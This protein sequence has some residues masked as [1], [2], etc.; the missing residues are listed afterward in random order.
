MTTRIFK[1]KR[2]SKFAKKEGLSDQKLIQA[3]NELTSGLHDGELGNNVWKKRVGRDGGGKRGGYRTIVLYK[4]GANVFIA[5]GFP[6]NEQDNITDA[7]KNG[8]KILSDYL[9]NLSDEELEALLDAKEYVEV[10]EVKNGK[11][12]KKKTKK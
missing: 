1:S 9:L 4:E 5:Y 7:Q 6:K 12:G 11:N 3:I 2:F 8:F 10:K